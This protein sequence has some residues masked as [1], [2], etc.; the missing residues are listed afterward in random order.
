[1]KTILIAFITYSFISTVHAQ[2]VSECEGRA[3]WQEDRVVSPNV[4]FRKCNVFGL[5]F[6]E[7]KY[8]LLEDRCISIRNVNTGEHW[9]DF[10]LHKNEVKSIGVMN[11]STLAKIKIVSSKTE[12]NSCRN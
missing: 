11:A 5:D 3:A 1:M 9:K 8:R 10:Y 6:I 2:E 4:I 7:V 12:N